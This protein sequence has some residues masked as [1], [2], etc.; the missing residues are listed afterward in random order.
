MDNF[1]PPNRS[2]VKAYRWRII[3]RLIARRLRF[4][5]LWS[6]LAV[7]T[8]PLSLTTLHA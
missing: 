3:D 2:S 1:Y 5:R 6:L 7:M 4:I 8:L